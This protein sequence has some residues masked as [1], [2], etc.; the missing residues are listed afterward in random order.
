MKKEN[1]KPVSFTHLKEYLTLITATGKSYN[2]N[3][4]NL[5]AIIAA[6]NKVDSPCAVQFRKWAKHIIEKYPQ[7]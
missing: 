2:I 6:D 4:Y 5:S 3:H 1:M 7:N